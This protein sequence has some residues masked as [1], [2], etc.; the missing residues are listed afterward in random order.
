MLANIILTELE[1][2]VVSDLIRCDTIKFYKRYFDDTVLLIKHSDNP[3]VLAK[4]NEFDKN[5]K[6]T[7]DTF[8]DGVIHFLDIKISVD[9]TNV[10]LNDTHTGQ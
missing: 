9:R 4:F 10:Y 1:K 6:L 7:A 2:T 5:L 3:A 8:P